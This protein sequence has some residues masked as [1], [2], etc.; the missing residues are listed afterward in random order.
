MFSI[1]GDYGF[2][3]P[4]SAISLAGWSALRAAARAH[5]DNPL[6]AGQF[7]SCDAAQPG[8]TLLVRTYR[9]LAA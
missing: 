9:A 1:H 7:G 8:A 5:C 3:S 4:F 2:W 6:C